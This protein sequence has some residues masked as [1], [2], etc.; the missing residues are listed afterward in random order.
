MTP[1]P[2]GLAVW[3]SRQRWFARGSGEPQ[4]RVL[5]H[6]PWGDASTD[7][8]ADAYTLI[9]LDESAE[10]P[11]I[12][13]VPYVRRRGTGPYPHL[14]DTDGDVTWV[15]GPHDPLYARLL[16]QQLIPG[17]A[18]AS[19]SV[20]EGE[21]SNTSLIFRFDDHKPVIAKVLRVLTPGRSPDAE[22][23][24]A[25]SGA[26]A[27]HVPG[28]VGESTARWADGAVTS[29][30]TVALAT[31]FVEGAHDGWDLAVRLYGEGEDLSEDA[32]ALGAATAS[33]HLALAEMFGTAPADEDARSFLREA[34]ERRLRI[35]VT[36][37]AEMAAREEQIRA[38]FAHAGTMPWPAMQR[39]H[40]DLHLG[41]CLRTPD[42]VWL[43]IDFE[44]EPMRPIEDRRSR[45]LAARDIAGMLRSF[46]YAAG[47]PARAA[48]AR[49]AFLRG[50]SAHGG[51]LPDLALLRALEMDKAVY[52]AIYEARHRPDWLPI[53]LRGI[54][55]MLTR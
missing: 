29:E 53:P 8:D 39:I 44:G 52:E 37:V 43:L 19:A 54:D 10:R 25:L 41:Q 42:G 31:D 34:W 1:L 6:A 55:E 14:I 50:Y 4:L 51:A 33:V 20:H 17:A 26:A 36:E 3:M 32:A 21:Q 11:K 23:S 45:D 13:H 7:A 9:V 27:G 40:G 12:Y 2:T 38:V 24:S 22:L 5:A 49:D 30:G 28:F 18:V 47:D 35:A 48:A 15:D 16:A 46:E